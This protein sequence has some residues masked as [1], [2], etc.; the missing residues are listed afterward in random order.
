MNLVLL[1][2]DID[3]LIFFS[4]TRLFFCRTGCLSMESDGHL[5]QGAISISDRSTYGGSV[6]IY[7]GPCYFD[8]HFSLVPEAMVNHP[9]KRL[10]FF[11]GLWADWSGS[12]FLLVFHGD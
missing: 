8:H 3:G 5:W 9:A 4:T 6:T 2:I 10:T 7:T 12:G 1:A 11:C